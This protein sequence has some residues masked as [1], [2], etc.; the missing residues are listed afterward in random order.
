[1]KY[2]SALLV[3]ADV[4]ESRRFYADVLKQSVKTDMGENVAFEGGFSIQ[5]KTLWERLIGFKPIA[6][7]PNN[8]ELYFED[9][10]VEG[11]AVRLA[12]SGC[13]FLHPVEEQPWRQR[14]LRF[15]DPDGHMIEIGES[16]EHLACRLK[17]EGMETAEIA[18]ITYLSAD[19]IEASFGEYAKER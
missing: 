14:V 13:E 10:D 6:R 11:M 9:D 5:G 19:A 15:Y 12:A 16:L 4:A 3:V 17:L 8:A 7:K 18:R 1:M 2:V